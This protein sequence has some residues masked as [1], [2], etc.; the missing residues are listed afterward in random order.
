M[1]SMKE[2]VDLANSLEKIRNSI[3][4]YIGCQVKLRTN[5][6]RKKIVERK[7]IIESVHP[8]IFVVKI[9]CEYNNTRRVSYSYSDIL[10]E[11]VKLMVLRKKIK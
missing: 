5:K 2:G 8:S 4:N 6:G 11:S 3:E 10:T 7:G 9:D 1:L